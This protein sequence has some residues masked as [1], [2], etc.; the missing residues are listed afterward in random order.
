MEIFDKW[1]EIIFYGLG[2][3]VLLGAY[4]YPFKP[5]YNLIGFIIVLLNS[6]LFQV[7]LIIFVLRVFIINR[8]KKDNPIK[9]V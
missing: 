7:L 8:K 4:I 2:I 6:W 3:V 9:V 1:N 5:E